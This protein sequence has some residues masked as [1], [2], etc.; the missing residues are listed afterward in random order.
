MPSPF[1]QI[2]FFTKT[3]R[4]KFPRACRRIYQNWESLFCCR[5]WEK[6]LFEVSRNVLNVLQTH[7]GL[8][9]QKLAERQP[10][11]DFQGCLKLW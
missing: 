3:S 4:G 2:I 5:F 9:P 10:F 1:F 11:S 7:A 6:D 8:L